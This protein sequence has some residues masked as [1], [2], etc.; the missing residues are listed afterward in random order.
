MSTVIPDIFLKDFNSLEEFQ[1]RFNS[2]ENG[3]DSFLQ[4]ISEWLPEKIEAI[5]PGT[6]VGD[7]INAAQTAS[8]SND[9][10]NQTTSSSNKLKALSNLTQGRVDTVA[11]VVQLTDAVLTGD[12]YSAFA[13]TA[14]LSVAFAGGAPSVPSEDSSRCI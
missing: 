4:Q 12:W 9:A 13:E 10:L 14:G 7:T 6:V 3:S 5:A 2:N 8:G 1:A 11:N